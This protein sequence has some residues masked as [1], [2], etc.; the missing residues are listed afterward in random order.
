MTSPFCEE[1]APLAAA[2][3]CVLCQFKDEITRRHDEYSKA[4]NRR[5]D[6][7]NVL[8]AVAAGKRELLTR[9]ECK[10]LAQKLG[11]A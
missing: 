2:H 3:G 4:L 11:N 6:V 10:T 5:V 7:E 1:C 9:E 8:A